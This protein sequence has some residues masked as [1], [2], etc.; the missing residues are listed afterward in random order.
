M[1][2]RLVPLLAVICLA[3]QAAVAASPPD[4]CPRPAAGGAVPQ[5][6]NLTSH[7]GEL[8]LDLTVRN[9][10]EPDGSVRYCYVLPDGAESPTLRA[11]PGDLVVIE[12]HNELRD[13]SD[14]V[15]ANLAAHVHRH[16]ITVPA[17]GADPCT[18]G[19]MTAVSANLHFH[20]M[21]LPPLCHQDE[22]LNTSVQPH[23]SFEYRF[24]I[25]LHEPP[26]L[27]WYH[28]HIHGFSAQQVSGGLSGALIVE[29]I[30]RD[31]PDVRGLAEQ[32]LVIRD[33]N[34]LEPD[35][36][37][38]GSSA[39]ALVDREGDVLNTGTGQGKPAKDLSVNFVPVPYP[40]YPPATITLRPGERQLWRVLN[41]SSL[42]YLNLAATFRRGPKFRAE[43]LGVVAIDG[44]PLSADGGPLHGIQWRD[45]IALP[46]GARAEFIL[47]GPPAGVAAALIT[48]GVDTGPEGENDPNRP[49]LNIVSRT[50]A[51]AAP[52]VL[53]TATEA[54]PAP[55]RPWLGTVKPSRVRKLYFSEDP[56]DPAHPEAPVHFYLTV[57]GQTPAAFDPSQSQPNIIVHQGDVE[58]W[59]IENRSSEVHAFH[60]HQLHFQVVQWLGTT[61]N[62]PLL[63]DTVN[64]PFYEKTMKVYPSVRLRMDFRDPDIIGTFVY[65]CHLLDHE[66]QGM[67][68]TIR[69][70]P[71]PSH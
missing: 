60:I 45:S 32:V 17:R 4:P 43:W 1:F 13:F 66:D 71:A 44:V 7:G 2:C 36:V 3:G 14:E 51:P 12:L 61:I 68:G 9:V 64:V 31:S 49:L 39:P 67:M 55:L 16:A 40:N 57:E 70:D 27:Y 20:G 19:A 69:V 46:P 28:P 26:G 50:D 37:T 54:A 65:H 15:H 5:P 47:T 58:D 53:P 33:Q 8:Y 56:V 63:R 34:L 52:S 22:V 23:Q 10:R 59:I 29:G 6:E 62:E 25:P 18:S 21:S 11:K 42:T 35:A 24:R 30:E 41:A 38:A 48:R